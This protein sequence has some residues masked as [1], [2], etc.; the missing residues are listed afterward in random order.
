LNGWVTITPDMSTIKSMGG[1]SCSKVGSKKNGGF[2]KVCG[3]EGHNANMRAENFGL[4]GPMG[5]EP[6]SGA[7][8]DPKSTKKPPAK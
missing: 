7:I 1:G 5:L 3:R 2:L 4:S 8:T 6:R